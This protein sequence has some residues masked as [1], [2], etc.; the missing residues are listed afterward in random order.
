MVQLNGMG[1]LRAALEDLIPAA[2]AMP[3]RR[4]IRALG[5]WSN[6]RCAEYGYNV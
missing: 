2:A 3:V 1:R 5:D 4:R 6:A